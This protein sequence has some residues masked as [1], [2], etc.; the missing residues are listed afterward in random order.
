MAVGGVQ[1]DPKTRRE[2]KRAGR[3][4]GPTSIMS[5]LAGRLETAGIENNALTLQIPHYLQLEED[6][7]AVA[8]MLEAAGEAL[9]LSADVV[10]SVLG[11]KARGERQYAQL[12]RMVAADDDLRQAAERL[13]R[14]YD[15]EHPAEPEA[16]ALSP[17]IERFLGEVVRRIDSGDGPGSSS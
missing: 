15:A 10:E 1:V 8:A 16:P 13:E 9:G 11:M 14:Q 17:E 6:Y 5:L 3:Y 7:S 4:E 12:S 2:V